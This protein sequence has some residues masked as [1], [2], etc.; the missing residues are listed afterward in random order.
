MQ[1]TTM[2]LKAV[3]DARYKHP[4][5]AT[6]KEENKWAFNGTPKLGSMID[7]YFENGNPL[8]LLK[9]QQSLACQVWHDMVQPQAVKKIRIPRQRDPDLLFKAW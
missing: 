5:M 1:P 7:K 2:E 8:S 4:N 6:Q 3:E 9:D